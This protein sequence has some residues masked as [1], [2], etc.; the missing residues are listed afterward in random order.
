[1]DHKKVTAKAWINDS[2]RLDRIISVFSFKISETYEEI[3]FAEFIEVIPKGF[4]IQ[5]T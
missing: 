1:V 2:N 5:Q 4:C 3:F